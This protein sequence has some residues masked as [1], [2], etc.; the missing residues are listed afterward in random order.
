MFLS[1]ASVS[2]ADPEHVS[3]LRPVGAEAPKCKSAAADSIGRG[4]EGVSS[5]LGR[6][7]LG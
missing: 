6:G 3:L 7:D 5:S 1:P 2:E 4:F